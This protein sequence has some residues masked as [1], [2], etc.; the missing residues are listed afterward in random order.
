MNPQK[1]LILQIV[2]FT[3]LAI[4]FV[5]AFLVFQGM[6]SKDAYLRLMMVGMLLWFGSAVFWIKPD[7]LGK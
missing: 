1:K 5:P 2:S 3:G 7:H 6:L 4:S